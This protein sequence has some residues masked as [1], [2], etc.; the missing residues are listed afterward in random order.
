MCSPNETI[1][2]QMLKQG[3]LPGQGLGKNSQGIK[4]PL[5]IK[6]N[7]NRQGLGSQDFS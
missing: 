6:Y 7:S 2:Q 3:F 4:K 5:S 1:A